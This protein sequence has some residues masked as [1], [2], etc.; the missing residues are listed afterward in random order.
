MQL[1]TVFQSSSILLAIVLSATVL[2]GCLLVTKVYYLP[3][4]NLRIPR[5]ITP[6]KPLDAESLRSGMMGAIKT[7]E[8]SGEEKKGSVEESTFPL[9][10]SSGVCF[11]DKDHKAV[12][13]DHKAVEA[14][15]QT[16]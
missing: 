3:L 1:G 7:A 13:K 14:F 2:L 4:W 8:P 12:D 11:L 16:E 9:A 15:T 5:H 6:Q 10:P